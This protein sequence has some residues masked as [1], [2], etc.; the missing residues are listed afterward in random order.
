M[1]TTHPRDRSRSGGA[2]PYS[3]RRIARLAELPTDFVNVEGMS[4]PPEVRSPQLHLPKE[5][6]HGRP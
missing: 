4:G 6:G 5:A 3:P 2:E 1:S